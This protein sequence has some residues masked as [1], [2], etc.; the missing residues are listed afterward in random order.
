MCEFKAVLLQDL[1]GFN[2]KII[3]HKGITFNV[4]EGRNRYDTPCWIVTQ[5]LDMEGMQLPIN[6]EI[7]S[8]L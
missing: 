8:V 3:H 2:G 1:K 5:P 4:K 6:K 7:V